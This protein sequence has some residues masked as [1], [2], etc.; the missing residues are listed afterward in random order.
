MRQ[1]IWLTFE[2]LVYRKRSTWCVEI[3]KSAVLSVILCC[4]QLLWIFEQVFRVL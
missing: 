3:F 4:G 2:V 1:L